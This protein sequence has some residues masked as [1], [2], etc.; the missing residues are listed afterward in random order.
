MKQQDET[1]LECYFKN[2]SPIKLINNRQTFI[3]KKQLENIVKH[4]TEKKLMISVAM[5][6]WM[7]ILKVFKQ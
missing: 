4:L 3:L 6:E 5:H 2:Q 1:K 7:N